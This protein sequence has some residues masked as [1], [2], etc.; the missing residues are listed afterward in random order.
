MCLCIYISQLAVYN[1][2]LVEIL[3]LVTQNKPSHQ[4][5][6]YYSIFQCIF[7]Q[8]NK[9]KYNFIKTISFYKYTQQL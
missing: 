5:I 3:S 7:I 6:L 8:P 1:K 2:A 9:L 4:Y